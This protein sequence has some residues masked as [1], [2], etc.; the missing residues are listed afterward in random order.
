M[1]INDNK[2][3]NTLFAIRYIQISCTLQSKFL[4]IQTLLMY[5][6]E[7]FLTEIHSNLLSHKDS[8][9]LTKN[10]L[11]NSSNT[12]TNNPQIDRNSTSIH[13]VSITF[14][15]QTDDS[16]NIGQR[17]KPLNRLIVK[18]PFDDITL[19]KSLNYLSNI[20]KVLG[21]AFMAEAIKM[22]PTAAKYADA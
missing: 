14:G 10:M 15:T 22:T 2:Q 20:H 18:N 4:K 6:P 19:E 12:P 21:K 17:L 8:A 5:A 11:S 16:S 13:P 3:S 1:Q 9:A 7:I